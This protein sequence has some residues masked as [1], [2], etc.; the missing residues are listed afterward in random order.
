MAG[1][2]AGQFRPEQQHQAREAERARRHHAGS[3][4][5]AEPQTGIQGIPQRR[6]RKHHGHQTAGYPLRGRVE[7]QEVQAEQAQALAHAQPVSAPVQRLQL[8]RQQQG[9]EQHQAGQREAIEDRHGDG[10][11]AQLQLDGDPG[12]APDD[13]SEEIQK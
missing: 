8:A 3:D 4:A 12:G 2:L 10:H 1:L 7:A 6:G 9:R 13:D 11:H 5:G